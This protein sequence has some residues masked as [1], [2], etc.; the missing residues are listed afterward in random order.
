MTHHPVYI[1][2]NTPRKL[3]TAFRRAGYNQRQ[4][5]RDRG[6]NPRFINDLITKGIEPTNPEIRVKLFL[7]KKHKVQQGEKPDRPYT[8]P[9]EYIKWWRK[10]PKQIRHEIILQAKA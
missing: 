1:H 6:V 8:E 2:P 9:P 4:L 3:T 7:P 5:A 10:Q